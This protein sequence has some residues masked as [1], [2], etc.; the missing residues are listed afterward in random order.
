MDLK[1]LLRFAIT[2][3]VLLSVISVPAAEKQTP[4]AGSP[5]KPFLVPQG[6]TFAL[7][8]GLQA[9]MVPYGVTPKVTVSVVVR[10]G[11]INDG[12]EQTWVADLTGRMM[13]EGTTSHSAEQVAEAAAEI[14]G[15]VQVSVGADE[16]SF[17]SDVLAEFGP[18]AVALLAEVVQHPLLPSSELPRLKNDAMRR[19][20]IAKTQPGQ[21]ALERFRQVLYPNHAYGR[22]FPTPAMIEKY[23]VEDIQQ[24]YKNNYGATRTHVYIAGKFDPAAMKKAVTEAFQSWGKGP[25]PVIDVPKRDLKRALEVVDR[26]AAAQSTLYFGL[27]VVDPSN[28]EYVSLIVANAL[29]GG[30][31]GSRIT[32]NIREQKGYTYSPFSQL[33][34]R[35]RDTYWAEVAD[36]TTAVTGASLK[37]ISYEVERLQ[38]EPPSEE[39]IEGIK[40]YLAGVFTL[41]NSTRQGLIGQLRYAN[42]HQLGDD[43]LNTYVQRIYAVKPADV[44][45]MVSKYIQLDKMTI[46]VV[47]DQQ[48]IADQIAPYGAG[49]GK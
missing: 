4:P 33:S 7:P 25:A 18:R 11:A 20:A 47:G 41:Q 6:Q 30:S 29:L 40:N 3:F 44:Q 32:A 38:K 17:A 45:T 37:E 8:N 14:G 49:A 15:E 19:L 13:K 43:Y 24:F 23:T 26:P 21:L 9:T 48:K 42:L 39:E 5:P 16:T 35:Y 12:P 22:L 2:A 27:P 1:N 10:A 34:S 36:V 46:V 31:F 28:P